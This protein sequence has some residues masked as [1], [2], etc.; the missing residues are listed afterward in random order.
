MSIVDKFQVKICEPVDFI[1]PPVMSSLSHIPWDICCPMVKFTKFHKHLYRNVLVAFSN[2]FA[3]NRTTLPQTCPRMNCIYFDASWVGK[4]AF[5]WRQIN[6]HC[7]RSLMAFRTVLS[8][9]RVSARMCLTLRETFDADAASIRVVST[10][11]WVV[12][13]G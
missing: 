5:F 8:G 1:F 13:R 12:V 9:I 10:C 3:T 11:S 4:T 6:P 7:M 2:I